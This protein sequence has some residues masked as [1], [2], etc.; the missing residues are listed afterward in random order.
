V[1]SEKVYGAFPMY[2]SKLTAF[3]VREEDEIK[4]SKG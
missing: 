3:D 4:N 2:E 1:L